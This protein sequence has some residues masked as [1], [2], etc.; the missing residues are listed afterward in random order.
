MKLTNDSYAGLLGSGNFTERYCRDASGRLK[1]SARPTAVGAFR[2][3]IAVHTAS[4]RWLSMRRLRIMHMTSI[5]RIQQLDSHTLE[6]LR[7]ESSREGYRFVERLCE[8]W[9]S[10]ANRFSGPG[11]A[12]FFAVAGGQVVGVCGLNCDPYVRDPH[13]GRVRRLYVSRAHRRS[14]VGG[15]LLE[16]VVAYA[17]CHFKVLRVRTEAASKF[18]AAHGFRCISSEPETTHVLELTHDD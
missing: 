8:E 3:A 1:V 10:G 16:A 2:S 14:G 11:E 6:E 18:Y 17:R 13:V 15:A 7:A 4:R 5:T 9:V 12:L